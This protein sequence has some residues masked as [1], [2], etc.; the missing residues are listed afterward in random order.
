M[1]QKID[2]KALAALARLEISDDEV[3]K[4]EKELPN[5]LAFVEVVQK[6]AADAPSITPALRNVMRADEKPHESGTYTEK[7]LAAAPETKGNR[8]VVNQVISKKR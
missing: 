8:V 5:I 4:L 7:L 3:A 1:R 6:V 2:V